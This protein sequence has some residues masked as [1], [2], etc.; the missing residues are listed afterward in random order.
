[1][2]IP[3][4]FVLK[5]DICSKAVALIKNHYCTC[6]NF[7]HVAQPK[8]INIVF[9]SRFCLFDRKQN[10]KQFDLTLSQLMQLTTE[11]TATQNLENT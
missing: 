2:I 6:I 9:E 4:L 7:K 11:N 5:V 10:W 8:H 3:K 1:M